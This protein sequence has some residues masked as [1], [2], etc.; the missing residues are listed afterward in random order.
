VPLIFAGA[1]ISKGRHQAVVQNIDIVPTV[2]NMLDLASAETVWD[3]RSLV[4]A[5]LG[6]TLPDRPAFAEALPDPHT[7]DYAWAII[8]GDQKL[9]HD[10]RRNTQTIFDLGRDPKEAVGRAPR[11]SDSDLVR[12]LNTH[13]STAELINSG[14]Y[15]GKQKT[16]Q[17]L[18]RRPDRLRGDLEVDL[19]KRVRLTGFS[20]LDPPHAGARL[21]L[22]LNLTVLEDFAGRLNA[23]V[24]LEGR[25]ANGKKIFLNRD[26]PIRPKPVWKTGDQREVVVSFVMPRSA[27]GGQVSALIGLFRPRQHKWKAVGNR[28]GSKGRVVTA[29]FTLR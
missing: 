8:S 7:T 13:R 16:V 24:H 19:S 25:T 1:G 15:G 20:L 18:K 28:V 4:P 27:K 14:D 12:A 17:K 6:G 23:M 3:G 22:R 5:L 10:L 9:I 29:R 2:L 26:Q 11:D 21:R